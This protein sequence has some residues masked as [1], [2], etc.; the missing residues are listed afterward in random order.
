MDFQI[1]S[2]ILFFIAMTIFLIVKRKNIHIQKILFPLLYFAMYKTKL[3]LKAMDSFAKKC[4]KLLNVLSYV[5]IGL[6][7]LGMA[8]IVISL[9]HNLWNIFTA[10]EAAAGVALVLPFKVKGGFYVPFFYWIISIFIIAFVH[11]FSHGIYARHHGIKI[12]SSGFAFLNI[13]IPVL[14]AAF[15]EPDEKQLKKASRKKQLDV[16]AAGP[17]SNIVLA[18]V[19]LGIFLLLGG[20][21]SNSIAE[22]TGVGITGFIEEGDN[23]PAEKAGMQVGEVITKVE[24]KEIKSIEDFIEE[25]NYSKPGDNIAIVTENNNYDIELMPH[26]DNESRG[27]LGVIVNQDIGINPSFAGGKYVGL[28]ILWLMGLLYWLWVLNLGIGLFNLAPIGPIDGGRM[29]LATLEKYM[30]KERA[31]TIWKN[32]SFAVLILVVV[33]ILAA[34]F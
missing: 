16:F 26:P 31:Y 10:P 18:F 22:K 14:P 7:F 30:P 8:V 34:F 2:A 1:I 13:L 9:I 15:V 11:E 19:V 25:L 27:M 21:V 29:L 32:V 23:Y 17:F 5:S 3:G 33:N 6:G 28:F 24:D 4:R 12:K 20:P